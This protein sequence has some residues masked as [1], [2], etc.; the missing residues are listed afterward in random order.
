MPDQTVRR[1]PDPEMELVPVFQTG[2]EGQ[3][4]VAKSLL[5]AEGIDYLVRGEGLQDL[6]GV[7]RLAVGF[8]NVVGPAEF[9]VRKEDE[10][11]ARE[12]LRDL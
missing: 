4:L 12:L 10:A 9:V 7:G 8:N 3:I 1:P 2:D 11:R 5:K 6:F